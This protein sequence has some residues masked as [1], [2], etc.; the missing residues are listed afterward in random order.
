MLFDALWCVNASLHPIW[1]SVD[2]GLLLWINRPLDRLDAPSYADRM[3]WD[4]LF[5]DLEGQFNA[6][7]REG[8]E[9]EVT[10]RARVEL[11]SLGL[12]DRIRGTAGASIRCWTCNGELYQ[13][14][15][16]HVGDD[17][18]L[19]TSGTR[20]VLIPVASVQRMSGLSATSVRRPSPVGRPLASVLRMLARDR[21]LV[22]VHLAHG[23]GS[24]APLLEG[25]FDR[26]GS[27][28]VELALRADGD[29]GG[30]TTGGSCVLPFAA[31]DT[32]TS[33]SESWQ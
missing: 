29:L 8:L 19:L 1:P 17:W 18:F 30:G 15:V 10:E 16:S 32:V 23:T 27:D 3:R 26:V 12:I 25:V 4:E 13:G 33:R 2:G 7:G 22:A 11:V 14:V 9:H 28:Y 20:S 31:L 6:A 24:L 21:A 5:A